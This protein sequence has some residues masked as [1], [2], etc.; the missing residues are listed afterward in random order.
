VYRAFDC[1]DPAARAPTPLPPIFLDDEAEGKDTPDPVKLMNGPAEFTFASDS[2]DGSPVKVLQDNLFRGYDD[3]DRLLGRI[4]GIQLASRQKGMELSRA[5]CYRLCGI[6]YPEK[7]ESITNT[8]LKGEITT[9]KR[10]VKGKIGTSSSPLSDC[11]SDLSEWEADQKVRL[12][13]FKAMQ[14][15]IC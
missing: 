13:Q 2:V 15:C 7:F 12:E 3:R 8:S 11:P 5:E 10:S 9:P 14:T 4:E 6:A 1:L